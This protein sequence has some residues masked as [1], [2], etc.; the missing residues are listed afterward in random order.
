ME[1]EEEETPVKEATE[2]VELFSWGAQKT[3]KLE[4]AELNILSHLS[5]NSRIPTL[6]LAKLTGISPNTIRA[7]IKKMEKES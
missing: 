2:R 6:D 1:V 7:K 5:K 3:V 4:E